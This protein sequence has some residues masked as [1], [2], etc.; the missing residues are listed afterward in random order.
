MRKTLF[1]GAALALIAGTVPITWEAAHAA[2]H[3]GRSATS[4]SSAGASHASRTASHSA[5]SSRAGATGERQGAR[6][7]ARGDNG[8]TREDNG[9]SSNV[10]NH[11]AEILANP[12]AHS[13]A[14]VRRCDS[15]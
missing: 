10:D 1:A 9:D 11:C 2:V 15:L 14:D 12:G 13:A 3:H 6:S 4:A 8:R 5:R 7:E